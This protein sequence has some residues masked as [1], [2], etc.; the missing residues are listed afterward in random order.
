M[1]KGKHAKPGSSIKPKFKKS[2][3]FVLLFLALLCFIFDILNPIT[4][5]KS[6]ASTNELE[7]TVITEITT[8]ITPVEIE[9]SEDEELKTLIES[10]LTKYGL[11][12]NNFAFFYYSINDKKY[13]FYNE[14]VYFTAGSTIKVPIAM[15][16]YDEISLGTYSSSSTLLYSESCYEEGGGT[17]SYLYSPGEKVPL[18]FLL[19]QAIVNSDN[20]AVNILI[21]NLGYSN[22]KRNITKYSNETVPTEFY[23]T[24]IISAKFAYDVLDYLYEN[25]DNY[26][27]LIE[28]MKKSSM[29][30]YLKKYI[31]DYEVAH[32]YG[33]YNGYVHDYG[34]VYTENPYLIGIFTK[35][36]TNSDEIIAQISLDVLNYY[37]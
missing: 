15:Y 8:N 33:S 9:P 24:N 18:D 5:V 29:G 31:S 19:E 10:E 1:S 23:S 32:K 2:L 34:I 27:T 37:L 35:N 14:N 17:T 28:N 25:Q 22:A 30:I 7:N 6:I 21:N 11:N 36:I 20:T 13:Y 4:D 26:I 16:Y 12:E 3:I